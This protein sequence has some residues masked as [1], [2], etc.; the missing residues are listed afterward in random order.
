MPSVFCAVFFYSRTALFV[1]CLLY[2]A[3]LGTAVVVDSML[4]QYKKV[5]IHWYTTIAVSITSSFGPPLG[6]V[7]RSLETRVLPRVLRSGASEREVV[8]GE[9]SRRRSSRRKCLHLAA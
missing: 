3:S 8:V 2:V 5:Y 6:G 1:Y 9:F 7:L 4:Q